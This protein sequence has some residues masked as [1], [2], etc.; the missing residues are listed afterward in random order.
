MDKRNTIALATILA[1]CLLLI[2][3]G[4][5]AP[6]QLAVEWRVISGGGGHLQA[7]FYKLD[8]SIGQPLTGL[9]NPVPFSLCTGY[10]C[11]GSPLSGAIY[12]PILH[13]DGP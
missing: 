10:W 5:A 9:D 7:S 8:G 13:K 3:A 11:G 2:G 1:C 6:T 4:L 12:I